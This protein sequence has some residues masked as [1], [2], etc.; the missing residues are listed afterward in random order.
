MPRSHPPYPPEFKAEA[1][2]L[3][4][5]SGRS[6]QEIAA[7]LGV[8]GNSLR[9]WVRRA[10][11]EEGQLIARY[12]DDAELSA[13]KLEVEG[14]KVKLPALNQQVAQA[15][16]VQQMKL[17]GIRARLRRAE[18]RLEE[19]RFLVAS[20]ALPRAR[21]VTAED[22]VTRLRQAEQKALTAWT[23]RLSCL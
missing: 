8:T 9:E 6:L 20:N 11:V 12:V 16:A 23:S 18:T 2:R 1:V 3:Y 22:A 14:A 15:K 7:D 4:H 5:T 21:A 13:Q 19:V 17:Q 10:E